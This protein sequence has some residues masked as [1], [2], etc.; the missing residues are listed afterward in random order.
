MATSHMLEYSKSSKAP[1]HGQPPCKGTPIELGALRYG[2]VTFGQYGETVKWRH[3]GCVT[4]EILA[5]LAQTKIERVPGFKNLR[6]EDQAKIRIAAGRRHVDPEDVPESAKTASTSVAS[7]AAPAST[8]LKRK[9]ENAPQ[10]GPSQPSASQRPGTRTIRVDDDIEEVVPDEEEA[11]DE[12]YV[13]YRTNIVGVQYYA[14]LVGPGEEVR[15]IREPRNQYDRNAIKVEN[16]GRTQVGHVPR[17]D[18]ARFAPMMDRGGITLEGVMHEGNLGVRGKTYQLAMTI[19][20]Y[21]PADKRAQLEPKLIWATPGQRGFPPRIGGAPVQVPGAPP[22]RHNIPPA[23]AYGAGYIGSY[24]PG[25]YAGAAVP[26]HAGAYAGHP[27]SQRPVALTP[28]QRAAQEEAARKQQE[29]LAKASELRA[30]LNSLE[31]VDDE[32]RRSSLLDQ[33]CSTEDVLKLPEHLNP[34]GLA[35]GDLKVN[36]LKHQ[37][38][39]LQW[40]VEREYPELPKK[41]QD[42]PVQF[43]QYRKIGVKPFYFNL[44]TKTPQTQPPELGRGALCA[45]SM[46][47][48]KTLTMLALILSTKLDIPIDYSRTT[49]IVV[50]LSVLSNWEKQIEDHVREGALSY[51]VYYGTGRKMTPEELKKYDIVLTTYQTVAKEH[52]DLGKNGANGPS[53]KKQK[54]EK[55]LFDVQ[56]KRAILD[57]GHTIRNSKTKMTKAVCAL[58]AQRRWVLTGTP[59]INSP[60]DFGSILKF[61]QICKPLDNE[62]FYKRMVLRPLKDGDPSG[63]DIM[64][65]LM[66]QIC[67]RRT[68]E[69]QDSEG[70]HLVPLPPVDITVVKVSLTDEARELYDAIDIVSK[71][72]VGKLIER[73]GGLGNAAVTSNVLS[74]LT[75]LRQLALHP[76]LLPPNYLEHLRNA[77]ENDDNP[78]PAIHLTQEDKV[79]LQGLLAQAIE[80]NEECPVCFGIVDEPRITSCSHVFCLACITEV[81]SRDPKCPMDRRPITMGDLIEPPPPTAFTQAPVRREKEDPD[82]LRVGSSAK[83][84]QLIHLLKLTPGTEKSLVFSQFTSF[85]DKIAEKLDEAG[86]AY[87]RFDGGMSAKRR[88]E[89]IARFSVP[90][91]EDGSPALA[92]TQAPTAS[93]ASR[94][95]RVRRKSSRNVSSDVLDLTADSDGDADFVAP[96]DESDDDSFIDDFEDERPKKKG[97]GKGKG[98]ANGKR[99][100]STPK[101]NYHFALPDGA[102]PK[103][104]LISLKAGALGLNLTV[105]NNVYLMDPWWQEGIESQAIDR[106]NRIGQTK[107]VHVYQLIAEDTVES[108]VLDIQEKKKKLIQQAFSGIK[109]KETQ[110]QKKEARLQEIVQL[111]G[112]REGQA[113]QDAGTDGHRTLDEFTA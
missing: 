53:Q 40:C 14:G 51:C 46:G 66:S 90:I 56:W 92:L 97:K 59:I 16:I 44:A 47:L 38:Q 89:T 74:M 100:A 104:M 41:E 20:I 48:G 63:V 78:A 76:G 42:K 84:E 110:R 7:A 106:C 65:G 9:A 36:L 12:L 67:I 68:K 29:A 75:R 79:R 73:H 17:Q 32:G 98:K 64:K 45:D 109:S 1:C 80:D 28:Q 72:R 10:A 61:L 15:L 111:F 13:T 8:Q 30:I 33:L 55:G 5:K 27:S 26:G 25:A 83:I 24:A 39:A 57:E 3:W 18:A 99:K 103:I 108:K 54:T 96:A 37:S 2:E 58:A 23:S 52:G 31:K 11:K 93:Q 102:N 49:L 70:N 81:I 34:P 112:L 6:F 69:M 101:S 105:A 88:Q 87:V 35:T 43:W 85:L 86:I 62:D 91:A 113:S 50:P 22:Q 77:A 71:E 95:T 4:P 82:N 94:S 60:A 107:P 21:G 19:K